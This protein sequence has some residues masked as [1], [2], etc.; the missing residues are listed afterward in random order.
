MA[1]NLN[2]KVMAKKKDNKAENKQT[3][4]I[5]QEWLYNP[6]VYSQISGDFSLMQQRILGGVLGQLQDRIL[7]TINEKEQNKNF[8]SLFSDQEMQE[9][10]KMD[11]DPRDLGVTPDH[12]NELEDALTA[13][14]K[15]TMA[16]PK[17]EKGEVQY[18][19]AP[20]FSRVVMPRGTIR[21][22][23]KV[24]IQ[25]L[26]ENVED[27][28][29]LGR[30]YTVHL[31]RIAQI[32]KK[33]RTPRMYIFLSSFRD[34]GHKEVEYDVL[35]KFLGIDQET[36]EADN[37]AN[38]REVKENPFRKYNKVKSQILEPSKQEMDAFKEAGDID[39]SFEYEPLYK[40]GRLRGNPTHIR[41]TIIKGPLALE[42]DAVISRRRRV[43]SFVSTMCQW[44]KDFNQFELQELCKKVSDDDLDEFMDY[45]YR[46]LRQLVEK[47]QPDNVAAYAT[48]LLNQ[49][50]SDR[51]V[52]RRQQSNENNQDD[53][54]IDNQRE[55]AKEAYNK[56]Y[57]EFKEKLGLSGADVWFGDYDARTKTVCFIYDKATPELLDRIKSDETFFGIVSSHYGNEVNVKFQPSK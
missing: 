9:V 10:M 19:I 8:P 31:A 7:Y 21:R 50:I 53:L 36:F 13:L 22:T 28:F 24:K 25:M 15:L 49:W 45:G 38:G 12:Y 35:C 3:S 57:P 26:R 39:F 42:R 46:D 43:F 1:T 55:W 52:K 2:I 27:F 32:C 44:C 16:F 14:T 33:K 34:I 17:Y 40:T 20:L 4:I 30:G 5:P 51:A 18:V 37:K 23:G 6:V 54:F 47:K 29:S 41:F 48:E 11:I 56:C